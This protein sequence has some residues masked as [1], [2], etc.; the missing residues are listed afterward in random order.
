MLSGGLDSVI[1][2]DFFAGKSQS[3]AALIMSRGKMV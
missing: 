2:R 1:K 3:G